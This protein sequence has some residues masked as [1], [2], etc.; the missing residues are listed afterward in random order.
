ML[1]FVCA[2]LLLWIALPMAARGQEP[3][4]PVQDRLFRAVATRDAA[5]VRSAVQAGADINASHPEAS[6]RG[7]T[8]LSMAAFWGFDDMVETLLQLGADVNRT[9]DKGATPL[10]N[11]LA[12]QHAA[13]ARL[14]LDAGASTEGLDEERLA[15]F[16]TMAEKAGN[17]EMVDVLDELGGRTFREQ[18]EAEAAA[19]EA[20]VAGLPKIEG[21]GSYPAG[22]YAG[23]C[24]VAGDDNPVAGGT[25]WWQIVLTTFFPPWVNIDSSIENVESLVDQPFPFRMSWHRYAQGSVEPPECEPVRLTTADWVQVTQ[26]IRQDWRWEWRDG[27]CRPGGICFIT[28]DTTVTSVSFATTAFT[29]GEG[30]ADEPCRA[31]P[32][33]QIELPAKGEDVVFNT[34]NPGR[35]EIPLQARVSPDECADDVT[36]SADDIRGSAKRFFSPDGTET[37]PKGSELHLVYDS[38]PHDNGEFG[39]K[40]I[41]ATVNGNSQSVTVRV[42]FEPEAKNHPVRPGDQPDTPNWFHYWAQSPAGGYS[43]RYEPQRMSETTGGPAQAQYDYYDD[44]IV[45]TDRAYDKSCY[46]RPGGQQ[47]KGIDCYGELVRHE[48]W[49]QQERWDWWGETNPLALPG[50]ARRAYDMDGDLVPDSVERAREATRGCSVWQRRSCQGRPHGDMIDVEMDAYAKGAWSWK[51]GS[52][53]T[54]DW[55]WCGKQWADARVCPGGKKW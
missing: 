23:P 52:A 17:T 30:L 5:A 44:V 48:T 4:Q 11:A 32:S 46:P 35:L 16:K 47:S 29:I 18:A 10:V 19:R 28:K 9:D 34:S 12:A 27:P 7:A 43:P 22:D 24:S 3:Q 37:G 51:V 40:T 55:S 6:P 54:Q 26:T 20:R 25:G 45:L 50:T 31:T 41:T 53:N 13:I 21:P 1:R 8:P 15:L 2:V 49:H 14:L 36:W 38:L 42:F 39:V 33:L